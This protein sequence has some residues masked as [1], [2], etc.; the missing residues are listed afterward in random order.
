MA[1]ELIA[2]C[3]LYCGACSFRLAAEE[4]DRSHL[5]HMPSAYDGFKEKPLEHCPGCRLENACGQCAIRD[6]AV[7]KGVSCCSQ[8][9]LFPCARLTGFA[10]DGKPHHGEVLENLK[11]LVELGEEGWLEHMK[12]RW[13]CRCGR[14]ISWYH[15]TCGCDEE[16]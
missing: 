14:R 3:G 10:G 7:G 5:L 8:C 13:T 4:N 15:K 2:Y 12:R 1:S 6:C 9:A 11:L 16:G